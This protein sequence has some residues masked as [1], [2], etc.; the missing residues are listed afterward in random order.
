MPKTS[1]LV[2]PILPDKVDLVRTTLMECGISKWQES[3]IS[4]KRTD[5]LM[6]VTPDEERQIVARLMHD[7]IEVFA[8]RG[9][10]L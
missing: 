8:L 2:L 10:I 5:F 3:E 7:L 4:P 9:V 6:K 1:R